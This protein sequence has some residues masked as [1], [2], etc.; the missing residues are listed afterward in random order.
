[1]RNHAEMMLPCLDAVGARS[2]V[3]VGAF[4]GDLTMLLVDWAAEIR[5]AS[6]GDRSLASGPAGAARPRARQS[7]S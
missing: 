6:R 4:A 2:I 1:M 3:E 7:W 5:R